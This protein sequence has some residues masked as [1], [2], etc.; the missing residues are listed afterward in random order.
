[1]QMKY[2]AE[3]FGVSASTISR[4]SR[5]G[6]LN[7]K[8]NATPVCILIDDAFYAL[9]DKLCKP[10]QSE[11]DTEGSTHKD[12]PQPEQ[13]QSDATVAVDTIREWADESEKA[14]TAWKKI[15]AGIY[16]HKHFK[17]EKLPIERYRTLE[18]SSIVWE[19][20]DTVSDTAIYYGFTLAEVKKQFEYEKPSIY[21]RFPAL[22]I[23]EL[24][25]RHEN[26]KKIIEEKLCMSQNKI[27]RL[28]K[29]LAEY[30]ES[31]FPNAKQEKRSTEKSLEWAIKRSEE[32]NKHLS[33]I[34]ERKDAEI[35]EL[36][37]NIEK[38]S[39]HHKSL[40][41]SDIDFI[42]GKK[43]AP[44]K[45]EVERENLELKK[46]IEKLQKKNAEL[47][48]DYQQANDKLNEKVENLSDIIIELRK[49][50][51]DIRQNDK[52]SNI[53]A[54]KEEIAELKE[55]NERFG[56]RL[57]VEKKQRRE[58]GEKMAMLEKR[59]DSAHSLILEKE[60]KIDKLQQD[61]DS[62]QR[63]AHVGHRAMCGLSQ[64]FNNPSPQ[65]PT[66]IDVEPIQSKPAPKKQ[67]FGFKKITAPS[68]PFKKVGV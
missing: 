68:N 59:L 48:A 20:L 42:Q 31:L 50:N 52:L 23:E 25:V 33:E 22:T 46:E 26:E 44:E 10:Y 65:A 29:L 28:E 66:V 2:A 40:K 45:T 5:N 37:E 7:R 16:K 14:E 36:R 35:A 63:T 49:E 6:K 32:Y 9:C 41:S 57:S 67:L 55:E 24:E 62:W 54:M 61:R 12:T 64:H 21:K 8:P 4:Y 11:I 39:S 3:H 51:Y 60:K 53:I 13:K 18:R 47:A 38:L 27:E 1:M 17:I 56:T 58:L 43:D 34:L 30:G 15:E 19:L